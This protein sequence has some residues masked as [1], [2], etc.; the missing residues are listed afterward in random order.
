MAADEVEIE[1]LRGEEKEKLKV[2]NWTVIIVLRDNL[3]M[4][5]WSVLSSINMSLL[6]LR[7]V[8]MS[9]ENMLIGFG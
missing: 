4:L 1:K 3:G 6:I 5:F 7:S 2:C 9:S 8:C